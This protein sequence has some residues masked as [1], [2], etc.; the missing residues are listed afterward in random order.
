MLVILGSAVLG[1]L[2][3]K[4]F[5]PSGWSRTFVG[6]STTD[7]FKAQLHLGQLGY[8]VTPD[9]VMGPATIDALKHFQATYGT[10]AQDGSLD[11]ETLAYLEQV[12]KQMNAAPDPQSGFHTQ[13]WS[14]QA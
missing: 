14:N 3:A 13:P 8:N 9:G 5:H 11:A 1:W 4:H 6:A 10:T 12:V 2:A 7:I